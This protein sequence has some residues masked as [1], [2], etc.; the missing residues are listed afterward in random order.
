MKT[1]KDTPQGGNRYCMQVILNFVHRIKQKKK[2]EGKPHKS[3]ESVENRLKTGLGSGTREAEGR[4]VREKPFWKVSPPEGDRRTSGSGGRG[5]AGDAAQI[6]AEGF[7]GKKQPRAGGTCARTLC[8]IKGL[9]SDYMRT[10]GRHRS[11]TNN[12]I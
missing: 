7:K 3:P 11:E 1:Q 8:R 10:D 12:P 4:L 9:C 5:E 6:T 2:M